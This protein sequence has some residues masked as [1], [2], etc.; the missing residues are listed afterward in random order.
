[1]K[2]T[3]FFLTIFFLVGGD[4]HAGKKLMGESQFPLLQEA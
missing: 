1:M 3:R 4:I 2:T